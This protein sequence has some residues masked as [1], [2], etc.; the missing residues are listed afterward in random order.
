MRRRHF[1]A[2]EPLC[3]VC[4]SHRSAERFLELTSV[5]AEDEEIILEG[6]LSCPDAVCRREYPIVEG[7]PILLQDLRGYVQGHLL[8]L[9]RRDSLAAPLESLLGDCCGPGSTFD[10]QRQHLSTYGASHYGDLWGPPVGSSP[11]APERRAQTAEV[12]SSLLHLL[13]EGRRLA[14][15][16]PA[17]PTL[18]L[19]C[20]VGRTTFELA[21]STEGLVLGVDMHF[22][23]LRLAKRLLRGKTV[24]LPCRRSGVVYDRRLCHLGQSSLESGLE[25][26]DFWA[27]DALDLPFAS[28]SFSAMGALNVI[29]CLAVPLDGLR[30][31]SRNL[32]D[33]GRLWMSSPYDW[34]PGATAFEGW[35]GGHSDRGEDGGQSELRLRLLLAE[36]SLQLGL[37]VLDQAPDLPWRLR[38]HDRSVMEYSVDLLALRRQPTG[39]KATR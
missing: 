35:L 37:E 20:A 13:S 10:T 32:K 6:I 34:S 38:L 7:I 33:D 25:R 39:A 8:E 27:C 1:E 22:G 11:Q 29:D 2:L 26:V 24:H 4:R 21:G 30:E 5:L 28:Q 16:S 3:P 18:D 9:L 31:M 15:S 19:G 23:M 17:G 14:G 36:P 12:T